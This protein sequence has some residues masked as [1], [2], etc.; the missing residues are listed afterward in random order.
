[1]K[2]L[3]RLFSLAAVLGLL[4]LGLG[5]A[6]VA[7]NSCEECADHCGSI[8]MDPEDCLQLYCPECAGGA[9][10]DVVGSKG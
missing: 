4:A 3:K 6:P 8:P 10:V 2:R 5:S 9:S 7:A 1:M